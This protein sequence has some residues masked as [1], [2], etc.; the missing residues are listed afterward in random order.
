MILFWLDIWVGDT[1]LEIV[2]KIKKQQWQTT[3]TELLT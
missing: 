2:C 3:W 1:S